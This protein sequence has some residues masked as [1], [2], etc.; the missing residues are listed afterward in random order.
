MFD[1][2]DHGS[3]FIVK[4]QKLYHSH[5]PIV[6]LKEIPNVLQSVYMN[7]LK[8]MNSPLYTEAYK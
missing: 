7:S 6:L 2:H 4:E 3:D 1:D 5:I 8:K